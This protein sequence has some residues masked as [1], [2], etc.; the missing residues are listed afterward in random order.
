MG[1][2]V[3]DDFP[4]CAEQPVVLTLT[5]KDTHIG[6]HELIPVAAWSWSNQNTG[7]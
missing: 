7:G 2:D 5:Y 6:A 3:K 4:G 1:D